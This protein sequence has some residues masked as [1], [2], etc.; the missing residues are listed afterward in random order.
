MRKF[1]EDNEDDDRVNVP[2]EVFVKNACD[3]FFFCMQQKRILKFAN[4]HLSLLHFK[5]NK[6]NRHQKPIKM[7]GVRSLGLLARSGNEVYSNQLH[8]ALKNDIFM[9]CNFHYFLY[10][11]SCQ[12]Y[13]PSSLWKRTQTSSHHIQ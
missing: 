11:F 5:R 6:E 4:F 8:F 2:I 10:F 9:L 12:Q 13:S 7:Q 1:D 3:S